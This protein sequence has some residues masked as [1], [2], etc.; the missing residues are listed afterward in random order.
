MKIFTLILSAILSAILISAQRFEAENATLADGAKKVA[1]SAA[2]GGYYVAQQEGNLTFSI[3]LEEESYYDIFVH[4]ASPSGFKANTFSINGQSINFS[5]EQNSQFSSLK[6][7]SGLKLAAGNHTARITK[8]WGW[9]NIDY[10]ELESI[11]ASERFNINKTLVTPEPTENAARLYQFLYDN[12]GK[13][14]ISGAMTLSSMDEINWLKTNTGK[15]PA[16]LGIDFMHCG[17]GYSWHNDEE[18]I[19]DAKNYYNRNG[20]PAF[21]WHWRDPLRNTEAFYSKDTDFDVSKIADQSSPEYQALLSDIDYISGLLKKLQNDGV[22]VLWR[23]LHEASGGWFWWGA[24][25]PEPCKMLYRLMYDRMVNHH[26]LKNL[27]W[28]WTSQQNDYDWYPGEDV[29]DIIGRDIYKDGDHSSQILE[30]NKL[31]DDYGKTKMIALSECGSFPDAD[32]LVADEAAWSYFMPW[33]GDFVRDSKYNSLEFWN[34]T[35]AHDYVITLDE[36]PDLKTYET[37]SA[38]IELNNHRKKIRAYPT[39]V[40]NKLNIKSNEQMSFASVFSASGSLLLSTALQT[41]NAVIHFSNF[42]PGI[43]FIKI[44]DQKPLKIIKK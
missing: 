23:P 15:E 44:D 8:S 10:I 29:V 41:K 18:P 36:M 28:V 22:S 24:K 26:G 11:N 16:L 4:A 6:V 34:K 2:S 1:S 31:N 14:I 7:I 19:T 3:N 32:N 12:Y 17:R 20:I 5:F 25:G 27:I 33:Y 13:K 37:A 38:K 39:I 43:Y 35:F 21:C 30:F 42:S 9:I 40:N